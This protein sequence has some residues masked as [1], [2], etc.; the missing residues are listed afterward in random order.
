MHP[1]P[2]TSKQKKRLIEAM[3]EVK[4]YC[5][6]SVFLDVSSMAY[7]GD[8]KLD[9]LFL[10][11]DY[12]SGVEYKIILVSPA[13]EQGRKQIQTHKLTLV[14]SRRGWGLAKVEPHTWKPGE[15]L[16]ELLITERQEQ[17]VLRNIHKQYILKS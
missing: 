11:G 4:T 8:R 7:S 15:K 6:L 2:I 17:E 3:K 14:A 1:I 12:R 5:G 10:R 9:L 13:Q 16:E